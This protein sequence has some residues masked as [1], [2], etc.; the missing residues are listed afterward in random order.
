VS[1]FAGEELKEMEVIAGAALWEQA[2]NADA[3][4]AIREKDAI[5]LRLRR[6]LRIAR[7]VAL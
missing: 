3:V 2:T 5:R 4:S 7:T 6:T 1:P